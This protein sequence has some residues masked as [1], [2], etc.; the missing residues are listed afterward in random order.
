M[1]QAERMSSKT[2][3]VFTLLQPMPLMTDVLC[4]MMAALGQSSLT[5]FPVV[6][7]KDLTSKH[8]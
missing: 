2:L 8:F 4:R 1:P 7:S 6:F 5:E 3:A